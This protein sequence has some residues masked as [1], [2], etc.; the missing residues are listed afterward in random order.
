M[1]QMSEVWRVVG[2]IGLTPQPDWMP[3]RCAG[4]G[5][6]PLRAINEA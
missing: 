5:S 4:L 3:V 1:L 6:I 2:H